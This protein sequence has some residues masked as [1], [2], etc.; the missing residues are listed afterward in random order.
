[1]SGYFNAL[2]EDEKVELLDALPLIT[3][4]IAG[5]DGSMTDKELDWGK[6]VAYIRSYKL[7]GELQGYYQAADEVFEDRLKY[8]LAVLPDEHHDRVD[9][10]SEKL[11]AFNPLLAKLD[12]YIGYKMYNGL[13][14]YAKHIA[15][16]DGGVLGFFTIHPEEGKLI[17]LSMLDPIIYEGD[18]E[19]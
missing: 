9:A 10:I 12:P 5:A 14:S 1:M 4:L 8:F 15:K 6:K 13:V 17:K 7:K 16:A 2:T 18:E 3:I 19:E 11:E